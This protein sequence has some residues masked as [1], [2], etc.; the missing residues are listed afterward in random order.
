M[1]LADD[2]K[3]SFDSLSTAVQKS[4]ATPPAEGADTTKLEERIVKAEETLT[5]IAAF[6]DPENVDSPLTKMFSQIE[7]DQ[8]NIGT[9]VT[10]VLDRLNAVEKGSAIK[11][12]VDSQDSG[13]GGDEKKSAWGDVVKSLNAGNAISLT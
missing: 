11:K 9:S 2:L 7:K 3:A 5:K 4:V 13:S 12:S 6:F 10:K 1:S 8:E